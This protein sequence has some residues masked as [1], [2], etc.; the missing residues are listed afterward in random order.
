MEPHT[1][2]KEIIVEKETNTGLLVGVIVLAVLL[3][4]YII[5]SIIFF[6]KRSHSSDKML[7][8][9]T[10]PP[11]ESGTDEIHDNPLKLE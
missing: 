5:A 1:S 9:T 8:L 7:L 2:E 6:I 10:S 11:S 3:V 4:G